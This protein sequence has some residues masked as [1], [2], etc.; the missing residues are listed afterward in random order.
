MPPNPS[1]K[2]EFVAGKWLL[3]TATLGCGTGA[4]SL[5]FYSF[6]IFV[7]PLQLQF[8]WTRG[9]VT[10]TLF[11]GSFGLV[12]AAPLLGWLIDRCGARAVALVAIPCFA[13]ALVLISRFAGTLPMFYA[14]FFL[15]TVLGSGTTPILYTRV[16][17]GHFNTARGLALGITLAGPGTAAMLLPPFMLET[18]TDHGWRHGFEVLAVLAISPWLLVWCWLDRTPRHTS[19]MSARTEL[20]GMNR[21]AALRT[22]AF[23]TIVLG[24]GAISIGCSSLVV[25]LVPMLRDAGLAAPQAARIASLIGIGVILGRV[26]IGWA[27]DRL[28]APYVAATIFAVTAGGCALLA[29]DGAS[30]APIAAFLIGF[31]LGAEVDL[32]AYLTSRYFGLRHYGFLYAMVYAFFWIGIALGPAITGQLYDAFGDYQIALW[33]IVLML[34]LG[35]AASLSLPRFK[36]VYA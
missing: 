6:G 10:S 31:A 2:S 3:V 19:S 11:Y 22:R 34:I 12:L 20:I 24:F 8:G 7:E 4:S 26:G 23:W 33:M 15:T 25:H 28:F 5:L 16:V 30:Q 18:I 9:E 35:A 27:I 17:A 36:T 21:R 1:L 14:L 13:A 32:L 29:T